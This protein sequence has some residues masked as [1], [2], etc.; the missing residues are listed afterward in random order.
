M[1]DIEALYRTLA[2]GLVKQ[3]EALEVETRTVGHLS[4][5]QAQ[6]VSADYGKLVGGNGIMVDAFRHL[7]EVF[8]VRYALLS[9]KVEGPRE[10]D[11]FRVAKDWNSDFLVDKME[12]VVNA[13]TND[14]RIAIKADDFGET[15]VLK[16]NLT[17]CSKPI[18]AARWND[19]RG[20][21][22]I[23]Q[24]GPTNGE[25]CELIDRIEKPIAVIFR[26]IGKANG[27][28]EVFVTLE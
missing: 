3:P 10:N 22:E 1:K 2:G 6:T 15:T 14:P 24:F 18:E 28:S 23:H 9:P 17:A 12:A 20:D 25:L 11:P 27:R 26:A 19:S 4:I 16:V 7:L 21:F 8:G 13:L 5:L